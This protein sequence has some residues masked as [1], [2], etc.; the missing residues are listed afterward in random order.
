MT[1]PMARMN[2]Q[3]DRIKPNILIPPSDLRD[4][5]STKY[6]IVAQNVAGINEKKKHIIDPPSGKSNLAQT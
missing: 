1:K 6:P 4:E 5:N 2:I 3:M